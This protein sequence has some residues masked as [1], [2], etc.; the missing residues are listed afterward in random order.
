MKKIL[1]FVLSLCL[2][3]TFTVTAFAQSIADDTSVSDDATILAAW[4]A[5]I[6]IEDAIINADYNAMATSLDKL[7]ELTLEM[8]E[9]QEEEWNAIVE[10]SMGLE[11]Y[12]ELIFKAVDIDDVKFNIDEYVSDPSELNAF[13]FVD[14]YDYAKEQ[15]LPIS[16]M[17][18]GVDE[19]YAQALE[20]MPSDKLLTIYDAYMLVLEAV[21]W[22]D[23]ELFD[24][25]IAGFEAVLD[26][27]NNLTDGEKEVLA[28]LIGAESA[29][30]AFDWILSDWMNINIADTMVQY[31]DNFRANPNEE[32]AREFADYYESTLEWD[33]D[34]LEDLIYWC[35]EEDIED[36]YREAKAILGEEVVDTTDEKIQSAWEALF[37][38]DDAINNADYDAMIAAE[39]ALNDAIADMSDKQLEKWEEYV[40]ENL[41]LEEY[42]DLIFRMINVEDVKWCM[43]EYLADKSMINAFYF[44]ESYDFAKEENLPISQ[45]FEGVDEVYADALA[46]M[47]PEKIAAIYDAYMAMSDAVWWADV[48]AFDE[49]MAAFEDVLDDF[50]ELTEEELE[51]LAQLINLESAEEAYSWILE[52]WIYINICDKMVQLYED[53]RNNPNKDTAAALADYYEAVF[54]GS[55]EDCEYLVEECIFYFEEDIADVYKEAKAMLGEEVAPDEEDEG[56]AGGSSTPQEGGQSSKDDE[57]VKTNAAAVQTGAGSAVVMGMSLVILMMGVALF[58]RKKSRQ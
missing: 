10:S 41:G 22:S 28:S 16:E 29:Q 42:M 44:V 12:F 2:M 34:E 24:T 19:L 37:A 15:N 11:A 39:E 46:N 27:F 4:E 56:T 38:I 23:V 14:S 20:N 8:T 6:A 55:D 17:F 50:N 40:E 53:F 54:D 18:D 43:E 32:T 21:M 45:M 9:E 13:Y 26:D 3:F 48:E 33:D 35:F 36:V 5:L 49:V 57:S 31:Y 30:E 7:D 47:P 51:L 25:A 58:M 1:S 52:D